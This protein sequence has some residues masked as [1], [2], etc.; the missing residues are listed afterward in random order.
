MIDPWP[1][2]ADAFLAV[3]AVMAILA[4]GREPPDSQVD[5]LRDR[6]KE[7][8]GDHGSIVGE[9]SGEDLS[10]RLIFT[11]EA[12]SFAKGNWDLLKPK[13]LDIQNIFRVIGAEGMGDLV[14]QIQIEGHADPEPLGECCSN[15]VPYHDNLQLS[16]NRA[17]AV[18]NVM[19][20]LAPTARDGLEPLLAA[21]NAIS[22]PGLEYIRALNACGQLLVA[23]F[24]DRR[25][26]EPNNPNSPWNRRVEVEIRFRKRS[27]APMTPPVG[28]GHA[29]TESTST[30]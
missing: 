21:N 11:E 12:L 22:P 10:L 29:F 14:E 1:A 7:I 3:L 23:G 17:R 28:C 30:R 26:K 16:Q 4:F 9:V 25:L 18:Y 15:V 27:L 13:I 24:G 6:I 5:A 2:I 19:L 20:G 8:A